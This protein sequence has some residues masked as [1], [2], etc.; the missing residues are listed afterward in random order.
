MSEEPESVEKAIE[1]R[2]G[3]L[4]HHVKR[5][6]LV[7]ILLVAVP[8][9]LV[10][11]GAAKNPVAD[12]IEARAFRLLDKEGQL[13]GEFCFRVLGG[14]ELCLLDEQGKTRAGLGLLDV[15]RGTPGLTFFDEAG[16][17]RA[18][19]VVLLG[20]PYLTLHDEAGKHRATLGL[21]EGKPTLELWD[22]AGQSRAVL[23]CTDLET[24]TTGVVTKLPE[25]SLVLF[26]KDGKVI[27]RVP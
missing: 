13:R 23:G 25:S 2:M 20:R 12:V 1:A 15:M 7:C 22:E 18:M 24:T 17:P 14:P 5:L 26:D 16:K 9:V 21:V 10:A 11:C 3:R 27:H 8:V 4:E 6:R 19:L